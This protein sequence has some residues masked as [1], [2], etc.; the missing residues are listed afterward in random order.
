L[1]TEYLAELDGSGT[2]CFINQ[3]IA[4]KARAVGFKIKPE[5]RPVDTSNGVT[6]ITESLTL[7]ISWV[8]GSCE[9]KFYILPHSKQEIIFWPELLPNSRRFPI[10]L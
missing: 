2:H 8:E 5:N 3:A 7:H 9:M 4:K 1:D 6:F 10:F